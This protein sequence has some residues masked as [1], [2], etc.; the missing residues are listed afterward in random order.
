MIPLTLRL[1]ENTHKH[2][3]KIAE[4]QG[5]SLNKQIDFIIKQY[6]IDYEKINGKIKD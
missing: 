1:E 2:I 5:R 3:K 6:I 4:L